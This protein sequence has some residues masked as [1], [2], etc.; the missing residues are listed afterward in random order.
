MLTQLAARRAGQYDLVIGDAFNDLAI[1]YHLTTREF[2]QE[3]KGVLKDDGYYLALVIDKLHGGRFLPAYTQ[4]VRQVWPY[5]YILAEGNP[6]DS[7]A[8]STYV[9]AA[10]NHPIDFARLRQVRGQGP[11][12]RTVTGAMPADLMERWLAEAAAPVLTDDYAPV[13]NLIAPVFAERGF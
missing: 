10:G 13:D 4:T 9:V 2:D 12:G 11:A 3:L 8:A 6:W 7:S 1:P 5:V